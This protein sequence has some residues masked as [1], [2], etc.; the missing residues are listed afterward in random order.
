MGPKIEAACQFVSATGG[1]AA[2]GALAEAVAVLKGEAGTHID[3]E[4]DD[5]RWY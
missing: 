5:I 4:G 2:I 1:T 3:L